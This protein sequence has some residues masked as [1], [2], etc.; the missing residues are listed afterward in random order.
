MTR[1]TPAKSWRLHAL[2][3]KELDRAVGRYDRERVE[4]GAELLD[5]F[6]RGY[7]AARGAILSC[8]AFLL[9]LS[10][11][12]GSPFAALWLRGVAGG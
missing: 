11:P 4:L 5:D 3:R 8:G 12:Q 7:A 1:A 6:D 10:I 2:A 9:P